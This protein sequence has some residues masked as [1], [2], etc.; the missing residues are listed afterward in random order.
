MNNC[1]YCQAEAK[2]PPK[3]KWGG[4]C[5]MPRFY[6]CPAYRA[7]LKTQNPWNKGKTRVQ[8]AWNKG[9]K[10]DPRLT[11]K[12]KTVEGEESRK[13]KISDSMKGNR[14]ANHRGD[15]QSFY[16]NIRMDSRWEVGTAM[17]LD[18]NKIEWK[19]GERGF[20]LSDGRYYYPDFF[21]YE[22]DKFIKLIEVK[23]YFREANKR[24]FE[25][26]KIEYPNVQI[27][28]WQR[29][30]LFKRNIINSEGYLV[31]YSAKDAEESVKL[32]SLTG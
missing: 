30:E 7:K 4:W 8:V 22:K 26:F 3:T 31:Q 19:Y 18:D 16:K 1:K 28:L 2:Y 11:G 6:D 10:N 27:E 12:A 32:R 14:N 29:Q 17:F 24:K 13:R 9:L 15:R 23:G 20:K 21:I 5:C 25:M